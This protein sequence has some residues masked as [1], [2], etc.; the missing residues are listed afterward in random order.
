MRGK[1]GVIPAVVVASLASAPAA[2]PHPGH[3]A[4]WVGV[5]QLKYSPA[6]AAITVGDSVLWTWSGPD[7]NHSVTADGGQSMDFDSDPGKPSAEIAHPI[8]DGYGVTFGAPGTYR[9]HC[10]VHSFM[11]GTVTVQPAPV[12]TT[13][14]QPAAP[15]LSKVSA[16]PARFCSRCAHPGTTVGYTLDAPAS[17]RA[18][19]RQRGKTVK[20]IDFPSPPGPHTHRLKFRKIRDGKYVLRLVAVDNV[21]GKASKPVDVAVQVRG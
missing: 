1:L 7:T 19:L 15:Q 9:Y 17:M 6:T 21:S 10:K 13:T 2:D 16:K 3:G 14:P 12:G 8:N 4:I 18:A 5:G 20:E 11:T